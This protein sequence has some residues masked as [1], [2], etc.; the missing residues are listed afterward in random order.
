[1]ATEPSGDQPPEQGPTPSP[2][3]NPDSGDKGRDE[4]EH[5]SVGDDRSTNEAYRRGRESL[6]SEGNYASATKSR[7]KNLIGGDYHNI[8]ILPNTG[9][10]KT[11]GPVRAKVLERIRATFAAV[12]GYERMLDTIRE[13]RVIVLRSPAGTGMTTT[14]V[15][16]LDEVTD[17]N[18][19]HLDVPKGIGSIREKDLTKK[20]GYVV[21]IT[22]ASPHGGPTELE[23]DSLAELLATHKCWCVVVDS[24]GVDQDERGDYVLKHQAPDNDQ[25]LRK[26]LLWRLGP[27]ATERAD[28]V[29]RVGADERIE[30]ALGP[31]RTLADVVALAGLLVKHAQGDLELDDVVAGCAG[32]VAHQVTTWFAGL[33]H[34]APAERKDT[35][36]PLALASFR[37][38]LAV[39][40][41]S[42]YPQV[43]EAAR[44]LETQ[45]IAEL[46]PAASKK[47]PASVALDRRT[48]LTL[49]RATVCPGVISYGIDA[50]VEGELVRYQDDRF[51][52]AILDHVWSEYNW[53]RAPL[54]K[55]LIEL[56]HDDSPIIWV[57]A[58]QAA[59]AL[60][61]IDFHDGFRKLVS[62][63]VYAET[64]QERRFAAVALDQASQDERSHNIV[65]AFLR[66]W[67]RT[68]GEHARWTT[69]ATHGYGQ[70]LD[71]IG[72][73]LDALRVLGTP[74]EKLDALA[75]PSR[76]S[77]M[78]TVVSR[79]LSSLLAFGAVEPILTVLDEWL[80]H[81]RASMRS[82]ALAAILRLVRKRGFH[83]TYLDISGG[84]DYRDQ[85]PRHGRWPLLLALQ[86]EDPNLVEPIVRL[87]CTALRNRGNQITDAFRSW[88]I[89]AAG[90][91]T[92]LDALVAFL[93]RLIEVPSDASRLLHL[94]TEMRRDWAEPLRADVADA[95]ETAVRSTSR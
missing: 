39:L 89:I 90:D 4:A 8:K 65:A 3:P 32:L 30:R 34:A 38:A 79:S 82:L 43:A 23:L 51:P 69:A 27:D 56:G 83:F 58:A 6:R 80:N 42:A 11:S 33:R 41:I 92:C 53:L 74:D 85:L 26:H 31:D 13:N 55:W 72:A 22:S 9:D 77:V 67:R 35:G 46:D 94:V 48:A 71:D 87:L 62:P 19:A 60:S 24:T 47:A 5:D 28:E 16:L 93:P 52:I 61:A 73:T 49:S 84:R 45:L 29:L 70:G 36:D 95:I 50:V 59:G 88:L 20:R 18:V 86:H 14:A 68:G 81:E 64:V 7:V 21:R 91:S 57:R 15:R 76:T 66:S 75:E 17:G 1:M 54:G 2:A 63:N 10:K 78:V 37:I 25:V 44:D 40:N 12:A